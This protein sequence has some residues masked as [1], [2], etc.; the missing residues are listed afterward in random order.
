MNLDFVRNDFRFN[1]RASAIIY[2]K[3]FILKKSILGLYLKNNRISFSSLFILSSSS[4][5]F[6]I[7][8]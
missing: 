6:F 3:D 8:K 1:A 4:K 5:I 7:F 2:N